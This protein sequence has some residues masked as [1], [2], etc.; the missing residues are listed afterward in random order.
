MQT[1]NFCQIYSSELLKMYFC[2]CAKA[3]LCKGY[4]TYAVKNS[5]VLW[6]Q[7]IAGRELWSKYDSSI[8]TYF[9]I[10]IWQAE[11]NNANYLPLQE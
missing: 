4:S 10:K 6:K 1:E 11:I 9:Q 3:Q 8:I 5:Y 2:Y 7:Q